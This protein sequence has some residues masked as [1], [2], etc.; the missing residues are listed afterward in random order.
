MPQ[1]GSE[2][3]EKHWLAAPVVTHLSRPSTGALP[4]PKSNVISMSPAVRFNVFAPV[5][6]RFGWA[7]LLISKS[8]L[9]EPRTFDRSQARYR[10]LLLL[11]NSLPT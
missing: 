9:A 5:V 2:F 4:P 1:Q 10:K 11:A 8:M 3:A 6:V 7:S